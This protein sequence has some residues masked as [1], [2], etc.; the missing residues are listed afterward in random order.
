MDSF[1]AYITDS[2]KDASTIKLQSLWPSE[3]YDDI[4]TY[5]RNNVI[6]L[7]RKYQENDAWKI[8]SC[9]NKETK[10]GNLYTSIFSSFDYSGDEGDII[11]IVPAL[12][13]TG[14][15]SQYGPGSDESMIGKDFLIM[16]DQFK[17]IVNTKVQE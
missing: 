8:I 2:D 15:I 10:Y 3:R 12:K 5:L 11:E 1:D 4:S 17:V 7:Y 14:E 9:T 13:V 6:F 16:Y